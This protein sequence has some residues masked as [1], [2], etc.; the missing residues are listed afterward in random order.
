MIRFNHSQGSVVLGQG[1]SWTNQAESESYRDTSADS[2]T[3]IVREVESGRPWRDAVTA[4]FAESHPWLHRIVTSEARS[5]FFHQ[6]PPPPDAQ[7]L[8]IGAGWGQ[9][10]LPLVQSLGSFV[11]ALEPTPE[12][13]AFIRAAAQ[14]DGVSARMNFIQSNFLELQFEPTFDLVCSIGVLEWVAKFHPG[15]PR[16]VQQEFLRRMRAALKPGGKCYV[17]IENRL[18]LKYLMGG[19]D[20]H[21]GYRNISVLE[22]PLAAA[23]HLAASGTD[24]RVFTYTHA[25]YIQ[26]FHEAGFGKVA[27]FGAFPDYKLPEVI[28]PFDQPVE[29]NRVLTEG[30]IP[31]EHD[32]CDGSPLPEMDAIASHYRSLARLGIAHYF[33]PS[34][35]FILQ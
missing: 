12:R 5:L 15:E 1:E 20:D 21:T 3:A 9:I 31:A 30:P 6:H 11:T 10:A 33:A 24:L 13:L 25:E 14:Q 35:F 18:G 23:K 32:G 16:A 2:L 17:G 34:Y 4:R 28:L 7:V 8:D 27:T 19:R 29:F 22:G 26:L